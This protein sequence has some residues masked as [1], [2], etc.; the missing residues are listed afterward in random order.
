MC[1]R[2]RVS[3]QST[4]SNPKTMVKFLKD[5]KIVVLLQG[6]YAGKKAV[7]LKTMDDNTKERPYGHCVVVGVAKCPLPITRAMCKPTPKMKKLVKKRSTIKPFVKM[8]NFT[9][10]MPTRYSVESSM[11][12]TLKATLS[13]DTF[14]EP[15]VKKSFLKAAQGVFEAKYQENEGQKWLFEKLRF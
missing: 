5:G 10:V 6:R 2:D 12:K 9:H 8:V 7:I 1:I 3:T 15:S 11:S 13:A 4:G 14:S